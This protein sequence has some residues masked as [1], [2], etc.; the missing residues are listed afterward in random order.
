LIFHVMI[1][2]PRA[3]ARPYGEITCVGDVI[4]NNFRYATAF[5]PIQPSGCPAVGALA[6]FQAEFTTPGQHL[7][8]ELDMPAGPQVI[9]ALPGDV[10]DSTRPFAYIVNADG[11][12]L[13]DTYSALDQ[14]PCELR[15]TGPYNVVFREDAGN[16]PAAFNAAFVRTDDS[17]SGAA[18]PT[19]TTTSRTSQDHLAFTL[20]SPGRRT[21]R[22][23]THDQAG[24]PWRVYPRGAGSPSPE[25]ALSR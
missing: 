18:L 13:C 11:D 21:L 6:A 8:W 14:D 9:R 1:R 19:G 2:R 23:W 7:C 3:P 20:R 12:Y 5:L 10:Q 15:G 17:S 4:D 25:Q 22:S 16:P 24:A